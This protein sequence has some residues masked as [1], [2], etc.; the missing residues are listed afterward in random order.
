MKDR[1]AQEREEFAKHRSDSDPHHDLNNPVG[2][3]DPTEWPDPYERRPDPHGPE[4]VDTPA[5]PAT[6]EPEAG[7]S[8]PSTSE[9][10]PPR[11]PDVG[12][13]EPP[14]A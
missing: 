13:R 3:P 14:D 4:S 6:R 11:D 9:P 7:P 5:M 8:G 2:E 10:P 1:A 12:R